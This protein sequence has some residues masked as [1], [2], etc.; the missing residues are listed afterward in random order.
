M[1]E[2]VL[3]HKKANMNLD[4]FVNGPV[5]YD[6]NVELDYRLLASVLGM[7]SQDY[8][9]SI[10]QPEDFYDRK[11]IEKDFSLIQL[12]PYSQFVVNNNLLVYQRILKSEEGRLGGN[13]SVGIGGHVNPLLDS[14]DGQT[15]TY[16]SKLNITLYN[17][18]AREFQEEVYT[19]PGMFSTIST[20]Y[21]LIYDTSNEVGQVHLGIVH[22]FTANT[23][24]PL[25]FKQ[26]PHVAEDVLIHV[27]WMD[28]NGVI[29]TKDGF[30]PFDMSKFE[31][32][33]QFLIKEWLAPGVSET[34]AEIHCEWLNKPTPLETAAAVE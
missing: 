29:E 23:E 30:V 21:K 12:L 14:D 10:C 19:P 11:P 32:W 3:A 5:V 13:Y 26:M 17:N 4:C 9:E 22:T 2:L 34:S 6:P 31:N 18:S 33:S 16:R 25:T 8:M 15:A 24:L 7:S 1:I 27:G 28:R 20:D